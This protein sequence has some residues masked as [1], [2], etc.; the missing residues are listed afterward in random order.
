VRTEK[1]L[2]A[3]HHHQIP[4]Q[5]FEGLLEQEERNRRFYLHTLKCGNGH[6]VRKEGKITILERKTSM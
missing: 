6:P 5:V 2:T 4:I 3:N 1:N